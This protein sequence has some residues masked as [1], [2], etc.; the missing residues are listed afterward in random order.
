[1]FI[2]HLRSGAAVGAL[3]LASSAFGQHADFVLF[4]ESNP[5]AANVPADHTFVHPITSPYFHED[6]FV[7]SDV[8]GWFVYHD[9]PNDIAL[10][11]GNAWVAAVQ[12]RLAIT[13]QIQLV[14]YKD[15]WLDIDSGAV[16]ESGMNDIAAGLKWNF[17]QNWENQFHMA[18]GVGYELPWGDD[19]VLQDDDEWRFWLS[20]NKGWGKWH[21]GGTVNV[22]LADDPNEDLGNSDWMSWHLHFDYRLTEQFSPVAE[23]NGYHTLDEGFAPLPFS[24]VDVAN[25]GGGKSED[26]ITLGLGGEYRFTD[27]LAARAAY[28]FPLTDA[29]DL[30][31]WRVTFSVVFSF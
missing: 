12:L 13:D 14:A 30:Y 23:I 1:M 31:G 27:S 24:G 16:D 25:L 8:R 4:G 19:D 18:A 7:T 29:E 22:F 20:A 28:E 11:G 17:I 5:A 2:T 6:S 10:D 21:L 9:L 26:V 3:A 15:G